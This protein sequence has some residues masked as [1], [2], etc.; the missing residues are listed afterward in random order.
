MYFAYSQLCDEHNFN[1]QVIYNLPVAV[2]QVAKLCARFIHY[3]PNEGN[4]NESIVALQIIRRLQFL[5]LKHQR[6]K[7]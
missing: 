2:G 3:T 1:I 7:L 6:L 5:L 4:Y